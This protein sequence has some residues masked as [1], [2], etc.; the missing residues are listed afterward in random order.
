[1][2]DDQEAVKVELG[3]ELFPKGLSVASGLEKIRKRLLDLTLRNKLINF[4]QC[5]V[6]FCRFHTITSLSG[7]ILLVKYA[8]IIKPSLLLTSL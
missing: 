4:F 6:Y 5:L 2:S 3:E 8:V 1:M 7:F